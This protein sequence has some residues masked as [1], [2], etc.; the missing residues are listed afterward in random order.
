MRREAVHPFGQLF[1]VDEI[2][3]LELLTDLLEIRGEHLNL[4][5]AVESY[6][7][8]VPQGYSRLSSVVR[9]R[10][11]RSLEQVRRTTSSPDRSEYASVT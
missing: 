9:G 11:Q 2:E 10:V 6:V 1:V 3:D 8:R 5:F 7:Q 4:L